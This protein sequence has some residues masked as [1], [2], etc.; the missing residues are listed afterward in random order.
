MIS[1]LK[2]RIAITVSL[3]TL[4]FMALLSLLALSYFE[5]EFKAATFAHFSDNLE[6]TAKGIS[7]RV[8]HSQQVLRKIHETLPAEILNNQEKIQ[9]FLEEQ[10]TSLLTFNNGI[11]L[12]DADGRLL[13]VHPRQDDV[14]GMDLSY[15]AYIKTTLQTKQRHISVPFKSR[16]KHQHP[17]IMM[18]EPLLDENGKVIAVLG[19]SFDLYSTNFLHTLISSKIGKEGYYLLVDHQGTLLVHPDKK[20][21]LSSAEML[22]SQQQLSNFLNTDR[23]K[24]KDISLGNKKMIGSFQRIEPL[25]WS[26]VALSTQEQDYKPIHQARNYL[27]IALTILSLGTVLIV[28]MLSNRLTSPLVDLT[29]EVRLQTSQ[30]DMTLSIKTR[31]YKELGDLA[32]SIQHL[33]TDVSA[34]RKELSDQLAFLQ[35]LID[36]IPGPVFYKDK[37]FRYI[38]CNKAFEK[39]IGITREELVGKSV[40]DIA[41]PDLAKTYHQADK[42]LWDSGG[43]QEYEANVKYADGSLHDV[44]YYKKI[45]KNTDGDPAGMIGT[46]LDITDRKISEFALSTSEKRFR[47]LVENA[48]DAF[49]LHDL[50]GKVLDVNQQACSSL[51]YSREELLQMCIPE[52]SED[53]TALTFSKMQDVVKEKGKLTSEDQHR[54]KDGTV[55]PVELRLCYTDQDGGRIIALAR[56]ISDR[57]KAEVDLQ[58]ALHD[59]QTAK[60][61]VDNILRCAADGLVVTNR[62]NRVTHINKIAEEMLDVSAEEVLGHPF[63]KLF[64]NRNLREQAKSFLSAADQGAQQFDFK[65]NL[66]GYQFPRIIQARSAMLRAQ[67]GARTGIVTLMRDVSRERELDQIKSEFIS[68]AAHEL[69]TPMSVIMGYIEILSDKEQFG[70]FTEAKTLEFLGEAYRKGEALTQIVDDLFDI[71]RIEAGLPLPIEKENCD[72]NGIIREV[73]AHYNKHATKHSFKM[74]LLDEA[75][76]H[77]DRNKMTQV[78]ENLVSNAVKYSHSGGLIEITTSR[79]DKLLQVDI[80]D[81][82]SGM[83][84][85]QVERIFDKFYRVD[86]SNTAISGLG[87]GMSIVK[88]II[89]GHDGRIWVVSGEEQGTCVS[90]TIPLHNNQALQTII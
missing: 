41:P 79:Q 72:M 89:E 13:G 54:R 57:K 56:D 58:Q 9:A 43:E 25:K 35:N 90:F 31:E 69:R 86:N 82:G 45:F 51:G 70:P 3:L 19:G 17:I 46:F 59:A 39:F 55:F 83:S 14:I 33:M 49:F 71:S 22:F 42:D 68:T 87:L 52:I 10:E 61:Q 16:Q 74:A 64:I 7:N 78:L 47:L 6:I 20:K 21:I 77:I 88:A 62:R 8:E 67:D 18:T 85:G 50:E 60:V 80:K 27:V 28:R 37:D 32:D 44:I 53:F 63:T 40:F 5:E 34:K 76:C 12:F 36:T 75:K 84:K 4:C 66:S 26:L 29:E 2:T 38:G 23:G 73:V 65:L 48:A 81:Q 11:F 15:Q 24:I 1:Q 30:Q